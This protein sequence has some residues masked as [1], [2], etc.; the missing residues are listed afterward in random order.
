MRLF[1]STL[2]AL[3]LAT[4][5]VAQQNSAPAQQPA[6]A[7]P[8][9]SSQPAT[10]PPGKV[11]L[12]SQPIVIQKGTM[13]VPL[14]IGTPTQ[15]PDTTSTPASASAPQAQ[16]SAPATQS[17]PLTPFRQ[18]PIVIQ[19]TDQAVPVAVG[20]PAQS[21]ST[22]PSNSD[23]QQQPEVGAAPASAP[24]GTPVLPNVNKKEADEAK[25]QF[26]AGVKL[27]EKG[28]FTL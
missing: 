8:N 17:T 26:Q 9:T 19:K 20:V 16:P 10:P 23:A 22:S 12:D 24:I 21:Q 15:Q 18:Q 3:G 2:L 13:A 5:L 25:R 6:Q 4:T 27:K 28:D 14:A 1:P 7:A 11:I